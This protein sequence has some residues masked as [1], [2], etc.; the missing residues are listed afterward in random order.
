MIL[1]SLRAELRAGEVA[2]VEWSMILDSDGTV[3]HTPEL[4]DRT[5]QK[6]S[7]AGLHSVI[8]ILLEPA[9][10]PPSGD[11]ATAHSSSIDL[12]RHGR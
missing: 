12:S 5:A 2:K 4:E 6:K 7:D 10:M 9:P 11:R 8:A 1:L 3:S